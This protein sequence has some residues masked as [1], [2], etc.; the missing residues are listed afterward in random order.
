MSALYSCIVVHLYFYIYLLIDFNIVYNAPTHTVLSGMF[1]LRLPYV[2][3]IFIFRIIY[4]LYYVPLQK[5]RYN[6]CAHEKI[7]H[8]LSTRNINKHLHDPCD[9]VNS[10]HDSCTRTPSFTLTMTSLFRSYGPW[11]ICCCRVSPLY[12]QIV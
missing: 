9:H 4:Q 8:I 7:Y 3:Y 2:S 1:K 5:N 10:V 6:L 11:V 12:K